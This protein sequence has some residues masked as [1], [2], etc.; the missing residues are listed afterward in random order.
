MIE[1]RRMHLQGGNRSVNTWLLCHTMI[2]LL[3][4]P[5]FQEGL[6][7][8]AGAVDPSFN[9]TVNGT[10]YGAA[11]QTDGKLLLAGEFNEVNGILRKGL[12][13]LYADGAL[14]LDFAPSVGGSSVFIYSMA[15]Q[16]DGKIVIGG[17]FSSV[18][19]ISRS[20]IARLNIDGSLDPAFDP[21]ANS[22]VLCMTVQPDGKILIGGHFTTLRGSPARYLA[23]LEIDGAIDGSFR[24]II[25]NSVNSV[26]L[27]S[28][29]K[30]VVGGYFVSPGNHIA[31][32][33]VDGTVDPTFNSSANGFVNV[34]AMQSDTKILIGGEFT[35]VGGV[36]RSGLAR[37]NG[38]GALDVDFNSNVG[39]DGNVA[40][41]GTKSIS[42][43]SD[44]KVLIAGAFTNISGVPRNN[45]ARL[46][47]NGTL[48]LSFDSTVSRFLLSTTLQSDGRV[49]IGGLFT[50]LNG[51][52]ISNVARLQNDPATQR[53][54]VIN[55]N[56]VMWLRGGTLPEAGAVSFEVSTNA[57]RAWMPL[58]AGTRFSGGWEQTNLALPPQGLLRSR[59]RIFG[60]AGG[61]FSGLSEVVIA[62][63]SNAPPTVANP[64]PDVTMDE[65]SSGTLIDLRPVFLDA[66]TPSSQLSYAVAYSASVPLLS[67]AVNG[68][69]GTL[70]VDCLPHH[71]GTNT[72]IVRATD[73]AGLYVEDSFVVRVRRILDGDAGELDLGFPADVALTYLP[74]EPYRPVQSIVQQPDGKLIIGG[75]FTNIAGNTKRS[76]ARLNLDGSLD[77]TFSNNVSGGL[78]CSFVQSDGRI[79]I[80]GELMNVDGEPRKSIAR[81]NADGSLD[82]AFNP[83]LPSTSFVPA[84]ANMLVQP[85]NKFILLGENCLRLDLDGGLDPS[86][87]FSVQSGTY[88]SCS[89]MQVDG[90]AF[91]GNNIQR[92]NSNGTSDGTFQAPAGAF[93][94][95][96]AV[97]HD[98]KILV[99]GSFPI[100][101]GVSKTYLARLLTNGTM[102]PTFRP[103]IDGP[104]GPF[105]S[106]IALQTDGRIIIGGDFTIVNGACRQYIARLNQDGSLDSG[107]DPQAD[108]PVTT[109]AV[110]SDG[111][112]VMGGLFTNIF[113]LPRAHLARLSNDPITDSLNVLDASHIQWLRGGSAPEAQDVIFEVATNGTNWTVLGLGKPIL[114]GWERTRLHLPSNGQLRA[115]ARL[116][117]GQYNGSAGLAEKLI[118]F[119]GLDTVPV[120]LNPIADFSV[121]E[122]SPD[123]T[124]NLRTVFEDIETSVTNM[125]FSLGTNTNPTL[126]SA[127]IDNTNG[128][129]ILHYLTNQFGTGLITVRA[130]DAAGL[131]E[132]DTF[133]VNVTAV[134]DDPGELDPGFDPNVLGGYDRRVLS[135]ALQADGKILVGGAFTNVGGFGRQNLARLQPDG[136]LDLNFNPTLDGLVYTISV[137]PDAKILVGGTFT[138][139]AQAGRAYLMRLNQDGTLDETFGPGISGPSY[140]RV[141]IATT[142]P[143]GRI[144]VGGTFTKV[145]GVPRTNYARLQADGTLDSGFDAEVNGTIVCTA[146]QADGKVLLGGTFTK[147]GAVPR[148]NFA[149]LHMDGSLD[150][151]F[152]SQVEGFFDDP[153][154]VN[155]IAVQ[156]SGDIL[157]AG[158]FTR[159]NGRV[160]TQMARLHSDGTVD[161]SFYPNPNGSILS[162]AVLSDGRIV[163][164]GQFSYPS[165]FPPQ[166][167]RRLRPDGSLDPT[168]AV[169]ADSEVEAIAIQEDGRVIVGGAFT[170]L[171][172]L[173]GSSLG[174]ILGEPAEE[175]LMVET[176]SRVRWLRGGSAS[177]VTLASFELST[178]NGATWTPLGL[179]SRVTGGWEI[180]ELDLPSSGSIRARGRATGGIY[181]GSCSIMETVKAFS[182]LATGPRLAGVSRSGS[183]SLQFSFSSLS[184]GTFTV[185]A[186]SNLFLPA[187]NWILLGPALE[188]SPGA[189]EFQD[190]TG[191]SF[192]SRF[193]RVRSP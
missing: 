168:F 76:V 84:I 24:P 179:A 31:R 61:A 67:A 112:V 44:G 16:L 124:I 4:S 184:G 37:L 68:S 40:V 139:F 8:G 150:L 94:I 131:F 99:G 127:R 78:S 83:V 162:M 42:V 72:I 193:Y 11:S 133:L 138:N 154:V 33:N 159:V 134:A 2:V 51:F 39:I 151:S 118:S 63:P 18:A 160:R 101:G 80:A 27:Q 129:L 147:I 53:I 192:P 65:N 6:A 21:N 166:T 91:I 17:F 15:M 128:V 13:R 49:L 130:T 79:I 57:G 66:E 174:R 105:I 106:C 10:V 85:D 86:F 187:S 48:D 178:D 41:G 47:A 125:V 137:Q 59:A 157:I 183:G 108:G 34:I 109:I 82:K 182:G 70:I 191:M 96:L 102:D 60:G 143:D 135:L 121:P 190:T 141:L 81:L 186:S 111:K 119:S 5:L 158:R 95:C 172:G 98:G 107:F 180:N 88:Y 171:D 115:R 110:Q 146:L 120:V 74:P 167:I 189:F 163:L 169:L 144:I 35:S 89:A 22:D 97:Q 36:P 32:L 46:N 155:A 62:F 77:L 19:G 28:D 90:K 126:L 58:G 153:G 116:I 156:P 136:A 165:G 38:T 181:N 152:N 140:N 175:S 92:F 170:S 117:S 73:A 148:T 104:S 87:N 123:T 114:G 142:Q 29:G 20:R 132:E 3:L 113:G 52:A 176:A 50:N 55:S 45:I 75:W 164:A 100:S 188:I 25:G 54:S 26:A 12:A 9:L 161:E 30:I 177:E 149:R 173:V 185:L 43:Q 56:H 1:E 64:I 71:A 122:D 103:T 14:D 69:E 23:R 145:G 7:A 93:G